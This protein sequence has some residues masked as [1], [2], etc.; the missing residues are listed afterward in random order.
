[1]PVETNSRRD[2]MKAAGAFA[3]GSSLN[4]S[5]KTTSAP[6]TPADSARGFD[7]KAF[8]ATGD[9]KTIDT[10]SINRAIEAAA[11]AGG[12]TVHFP[13]G[14]YLCY[15]IR[16]KTGVPHHKRLRACHFRRPISKCIASPRQRVG[17]GD[18][19]GCCL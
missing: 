7:V 10:P 5:R 1:M 13:A 8:G 15:S 14:T 18:E 9:G 2:F 16:L 17:P 19:P 3:A 11:A 4:S 12:G 6:P